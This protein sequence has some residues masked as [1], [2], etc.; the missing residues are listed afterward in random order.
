[1][2]LMYGPN[3]GF[4]CDCETSNF[5]KVGF[6]LYS[7]HLWLLASQN[8]PANKMKV[9]IFLPLVHLF[10]HLTRGLTYIWCYVGELGIK[11]SEPTII[12]SF[13]RDDTFNRYWVVVVALAAL[14]RWPRGCC[15]CTAMTDWMPCVVQPAACSRAV[16]FIVYMGHRCGQQISTNKY[17]IVTH[18][19]TRW[20]N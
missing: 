19:H 14:A 15:C 7:P 5:A 17:L 8:I 1:M 10:F 20:A 13:V 4:L 12:G 2:T 18:W 16:Q 6:Q 3:R 11:W 9:E